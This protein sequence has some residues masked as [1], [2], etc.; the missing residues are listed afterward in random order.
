[1]TFAFRALLPS[2]TILLRDLVGCDSPLQMEM[3]ILR[4]FFK[5]EARQMAINLNPEEER[6][7]V[8]TLLT[9]LNEKFCVGLDLSPSSDRS[10]PPPL[11]EHNNGGTV[12]IGGSNLGRIA[13]AAAE[14]GNMVNWS[15]V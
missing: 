7:F 14:N 4:F 1:M 10:I 11:T 15:L 8:S 3:A 9:E 6:V 2:A 5:M 12:F 13:K